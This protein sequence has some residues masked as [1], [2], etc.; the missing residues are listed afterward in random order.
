MAGHPMMNDARGNSDPTSRY[1]L[2]LLLREHAG[3]RKAFSRI[4]QINV[5]T[6]KDC[7]YTV[8]TRSSLM[9]RVMN[10]QLGMHAFGQ[11]DKFFK[12][13][14]AP[15]NFQAAA[16]QGVAASKELYEKAA[17][18]GQDNLKALTEIAETAWGSTK[19][20]NEKAV[21]NVMANW[22]AIFDVAQA[23]ASAK[24]PAEIA[25]LQSD[26]V[27]KFAAKATDQTKEFVDLSTRATQHVFERVQAVTA[28]SFKHLR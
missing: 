28:T 16:E 20:L 7:A 5:A 3:H 18:A 23:I 1:L 27:Q 13:L 22:A 11:A 8:G 21:H 12:D 14:L 17:I 9:D 26:F 19:T 25:K 24:S 10:Q 2:S 6:H 4:A 15:G